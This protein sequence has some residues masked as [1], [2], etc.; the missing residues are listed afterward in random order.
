M[1][2]SVAHKHSPDLSSTDRSPRTQRRARQGET[3]SRVGPASNGAVGAGRE[4]RTP[5]GSRAVSRTSSAGS[6]GSRR[7]STARPPSTSEAAKTDIPGSKTGSSVKVS[8]GDDSKPKR[9]LSKDDKS[10]TTPVKKASVSN[11]HSDEGRLKKTSPLVSRKMSSSATRPPSNGSSREEMKQKR[12]S[13]GTIRKQSATAKTASSSSGGGG[14]TGGKATGTPIRSTSGKDA[15]SKERKQGAT[16]KSGKSEK[17]RDLKDA[18]Q[19]GVRVDAAKNEDEKT[20]KE[21]KNNEKKIKTESADGRNSTMEKK[22][23]NKQNGPEGESTS[24]EKPRNEAMESQEKEK[25][26][27]SG[28][29]PGKGGNSP[30]R[31]RKAAGERRATG[32]GMGAGS[33]GRERKATVGKRPSIAGDTQGKERRA[34]NEKRVSCN[35]DGSAKSCKFSAP[36]HKPSSPRLGRSPLTNAGTSASTNEGKRAGVSSL[37][38]KTASG[39]LLS[40]SRAPPCSS[41]A[42]SSSSQ[43]PPSSSIASSKTLSGKVITLDPEHLKEDARVLSTLKLFGVKGGVGSRPTVHKMSKGTIIKSVG[44][45]TMSGTKNPT[46]RKV[47][48]AAGVR[49]VTRTGSVA[50]LNKKSSPKMSPKINEPRKRIRSSEDLLK[51]SHAPSSLEAAVTAKVGGQTSLSD[52]VHKTSNVR[53]QAAVPS[54]S[55]PR[56][57]QRVSSIP[58]S[59]AKTRAAERKTEGPARV[60]SAATSRAAGK[61]MG[62]LTRPSCRGTQV[63]SR[64]ALWSEKEKEVEGMKRSVSPLMSVPASRITSATSL[65][66]SPSL[67]ASPSPRISPR[68]SPHLSPYPSSPQPSPNHSPSHSPSRL[69]ATPSPQPSPKSS[70][71]PPSPSHSPSQLSRSRSPSKDSPSKASPTPYHPPLP[72]KPSLS[73]SAIKSSP[74]RPSPSRSSHSPSPRISPSASPRALRRRTPVKTRPATSPLHDPTTSRRGSKGR[75]LSPDQQLKKTELNAKEEQQAGEND[76]YDDIAVLSSKEKDVKKPPT[77][78][79]MH[80]IAVPS[81]KEKVTEK[82]VTEDDVYEDIVGVKK[83]DGKKPATE[84][85]VYDDIAA[86]SSK[87]RDGVKPASA[88]SGGVA[89]PNTCDE[90]YEDVAPPILERSKLGIKETGEKV[91]NG[92]DSLLAPVEDVYEDTALLPPHLAALSSSSAATDGEDESHSHTSASANKPPTPIQETC[93]VEEQSATETAPAVQEDNIYTTIPEIYTNYPKFVDTRNPPDLPPRPLTPK[94]NQQNHDT[95][96]PSRPEEVVEE[97]YD[98]IR[99]SHQQKKPDLE[100]SYALVQVIEETSEH[101]DVHTDA[102]VVQKADSLDIPKNRR[103]WLRSPLFNRRRHSDGKEQQTEGGSSDQEIISQ[104]K[105]DGF[106]KKLGKL[107]SR[108]SKKKKS[109]KKR[110]STLFDSFDSSHSFSITSKTSS[111]NSDSEEGSSSDVSSTSPAVQPRDKAPLPADVSER[112]PVIV[113]SRSFS[114]SPDLEVEYVIASRKRLDPRSQRV[115]SDSAVD[116]ST[117]SPAS[118]AGGK[119]SECGVGTAQFESEIGAKARVSHASKLKSKTSAIRKT[120]SLSARSTKIHRTEG[121]KNLSH[122]ILAIIESMKGSELLEQYQKKLSPPPPEGGSGSAPGTSR[123]IP[124]VLFQLKNSSSHPNLVTVGFDVPETVKKS[125]HSASSSPLP[126]GVSVVRRQGLVREQ[127]SDSSTGTDEEETPPRELGEGEGERE[128]EEMAVVDME[129]SQSCPIESSLDSTVAS[130]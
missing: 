69:S 43:A 118:G 108:G 81:Y 79:N 111:D 107:G 11:A 97:I 15:G 64:I 76:V 28:K 96:L 99:P 17:D 25:K 112:E 16:E 23:E 102:K 123:L 114:P 37:D 91:L 27:S 3:K 21:K 75:S 93:A 87:E 48:G 33:P 6:T 46:V 67:S 77:E 45:G 1:S 2:A 51:D 57:Q 38:R 52:R 73:L 53:S 4:K 59:S 92:G 85:D 72:P 65:H 98:E 41:R 115:V 56:D 62:I 14:G 29:A 90:I 83:S 89:V 119:E 130:R 126:N 71:L 40:S 121:G 5:T 68:S 24:T 113:R 31:E 50:T 84:D 78:S 60:N 80:D 12:T 100:H 19:V 61:G 30:G 44:V 101:S 82:L 104:K 95:D 106:I 74:P 36:E 20:E 55:G 47:G 42:P 110:K 34:S 54:K 13:P 125:S 10:S 109:N 39:A 120:A 18:D 8:S 63:K 26:V 94:D 129:E 105:D 127:A 49:Q 86:V 103:N 66:R 122:D 35:T 22:P 32:G 116:P 88:G 7:S 117:E 128:G 70:S 124:P 9:S 58:P